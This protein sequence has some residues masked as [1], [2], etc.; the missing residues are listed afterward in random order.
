MTKDELR[1]E[2]AKIFQTIN[3]LFEG[4]DDNS[5]MYVIINLVAS[6]VL[7]IRSKGPDAIVDLTED[8]FAEIREAILVNLGDDPNTPTIEELLRIARPQ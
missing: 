8:I 6:H 1:V 2:A 4:V 5:Q 3:D 7:R